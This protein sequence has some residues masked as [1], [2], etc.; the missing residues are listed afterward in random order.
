ERLR[1][2]VGVMEP[3]LLL[4]RPALIEPNGL[5][6]GRVVGQRDHKLVAVDVETE[7]ACTDD[8]GSPRQHADDPCAAP[9]HL[10]LPP[11]SHSAPVALLWAFLVVVQRWHRRAGARLGVS[12]GVSPGAAL[13]R[14]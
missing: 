6:D 13:V 11:L 14:A 5:L 10:R 4:R 1:A 7:R 12:L 2:L 3:V 9:G 8:E